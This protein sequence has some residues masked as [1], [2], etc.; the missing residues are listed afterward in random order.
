M[1]S[2]HIALAARRLA[3]LEPE[4][5]G[6]CA[7]LRAELVALRRLDAMFAAARPAA[8]LDA[9]AV[10]ELL[11]RSRAKPRVLLGAVAAWAEEVE[12]RAQVG[13]ASWTWT[14]AEAELLALARA[15][16]VQS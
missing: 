12:A 10:T 2:E 11:L 6:A 5:P 4:Q 13:N 16:R 1:I 7:L 3:N 8:V 15:L 14:D 9:L